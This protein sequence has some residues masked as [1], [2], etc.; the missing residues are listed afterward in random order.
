[1]SMFYHISP[2]DEY[3]LVHCSNALRA[4]LGADLASSLPLLLAKIKETSL[5]AQSLCGWQTDSG[6]FRHAD[7]TF[8][9]SH[10]PHE[11]VNIAPLRTRA[12]DTVI[13]YWIYP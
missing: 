1:M 9:G 10:A 12:L 4:N 2:E 6:D 7:L 8:A 11:C 3:R 13:F 5:A